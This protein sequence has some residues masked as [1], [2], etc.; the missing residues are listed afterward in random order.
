MQSTSGY[1][2]SCNIDFLEIVV[3]LLGIS[4]IFIM[5]CFHS[6]QKREPPGYEDPTI[7]AEETACESF[8]FERAQILSSTSH[9]WVQR[10]LSSFLNSVQADNSKR[11][12]NPCCCL[13]YILFEIDRTS[14]SGQYELWEECVSK[15][16]QALCCQSCSPPKYTVS[17]S[18]H[19]KAILM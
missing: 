2:P 4:L 3:A 9:G 17:S 13:D 12:R 7:L 10:L 18:K 16:Y 6:K 1:L 11:L 14:K 19:F 5:G 15:K 8:L